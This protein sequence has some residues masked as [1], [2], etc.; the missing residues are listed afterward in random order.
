VAF[1]LENGLHEVGSRSILV[2][3]IGSSKGGMCIRNAPM[4]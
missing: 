4:T 2:Q 1:K 3:L